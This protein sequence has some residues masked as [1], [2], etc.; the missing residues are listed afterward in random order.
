MNDNEL[1]EDRPLFSSEFNAH[2]QN[3]VSIAIFNLSL[4]FK[5]LTEIL[6]HL[7]SGIS[8]DTWFS[9]A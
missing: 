2:S 7:T 8:S 4:S 5:R 6:L 9:F 3:P 1:D